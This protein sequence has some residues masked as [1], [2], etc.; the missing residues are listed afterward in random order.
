MKHSNTSDR[1]FSDYQPDSFSEKGYYKFQQLGIFHS[2]FSLPLPPGYLRTGENQLLASILFN[3]Q[4]SV[5]VA[6]CGAGLKMKGKN[7]SSH[8][9]SY[10]CLTHPLSFFPKQGLAEAAVA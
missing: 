6:V 1:V 3:I 5:I 10:F 2:V 4:S 8:T 7:I 9:D